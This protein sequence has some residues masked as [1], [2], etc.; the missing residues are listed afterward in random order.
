[1]R[2]PGEWD[3]GFAADIARLLVMRDLAN[4]ALVEVRSLLAQTVP[5][6]PSSSRSMERR[7]S[8]RS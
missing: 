2:P 6:P 3:A 4:A 7:V 8:P 1:M 5:W